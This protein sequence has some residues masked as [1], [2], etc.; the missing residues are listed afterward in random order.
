LFL[1]RLKK[2]PGGARRDRRNC[3]NLVIA[4]IEKP[5]AINHKGH[6]GTQRRRDKATTITEIAG[7]RT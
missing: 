6:E 7:N 3:Q 4:K 1:T 5:K 2:R